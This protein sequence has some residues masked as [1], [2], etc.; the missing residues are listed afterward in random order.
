MC[1]QHPPL[2][3]GLPTGRC[4]KLP[5]TRTKCRL[6]HKMGGPALP[7]TKVV[8]GRPQCTEPDRRWALPLYLSLWSIAA[9]SWQ[10]TEGSKG[11]PVCPTLGGES[12]CGKERRGGGGGIDPSTDHPTPEGS[13]SDTLLTA[14]P[15]R[16]D[17]PMA[18]ASSV[19]PSNART[20]ASSR[21]RRIWSRPSEPD[22]PG[23]PPNNPP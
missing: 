8:P 5:L 3:C 23:P 21:R 20:T 2:S 16:D 19:S 13:D 14:G 4:Q 1:V 7:S 18:R 15:G 17:S 9:G 10:G 12:F 11:S 6:P 22:G